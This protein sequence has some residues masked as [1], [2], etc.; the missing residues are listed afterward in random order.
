MSWIPKNISTHRFLA[1]YGGKAKARESLDKQGHF[2]TLAK[3]SNILTEA[4]P[5]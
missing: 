5:I 1:Y 2:N 3:K 4:L